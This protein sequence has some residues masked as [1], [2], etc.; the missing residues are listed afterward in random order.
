[1]IDEQKSG[2]VV[3]LFVPSPEHRFHISVSPPFFS[4]YLDVFASIESA[5]RVEKRHMGCVGK[6]NTKNSI[7]Q[8][9]LKRTV[10]ISTHH[11][12]SSV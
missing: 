4:L 12:Q 8:V 5:S 3:T 10:Y 6:A 9:S 7:T 1:M 11:H 2:Q